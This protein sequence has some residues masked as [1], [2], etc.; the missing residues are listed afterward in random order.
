MVSFDHDW[1]TL[2]LMRML[3]VFITGKGCPLA[4]GCVEEVGVREPTC[5]SNSIIEVR[6]HSSSSLPSPS[7]ALKKKFLKKFRTIQS[8]SQQSLSLGAC[9][10]KNLNFQWH[11]ML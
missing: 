6:C 4:N 3:I 11:H 8:L 10:I 2:T 1:L 7:P 9:L 5:T